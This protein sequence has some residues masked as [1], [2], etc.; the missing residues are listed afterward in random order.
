MRT[1]KQTNRSKTLACSYL[2]AK[3]GS[4]I[5]RAFVCACETVDLITL[6]CVSLFL[7]SFSWLNSVKGHMRSRQT[8]TRRPGPSLWRRSGPSSSSS[9]LLLQLLLLL[10]PTCTHGHTHPSSQGSPILF[11]SLPLYSVAAT[12]SILCGFWF[13]VVFRLIVSLSRG[14]NK[15]KCNLCTRASYTRKEGKEGEEGR[16]GKWGVGERGRGRRHHQHPVFLSLPHPSFR[17]YPPFPAPT[18]PVSL[19]LSLRDC[20]RFVVVFWSLFDC[21]SALLLLLLVTSSFNSLVFFS[22]CDFI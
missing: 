16:E 22:L 14:G 1:R 18:S 5:E 11:L 17:S 9:S 21:L 4:I 12:L 7:S 13:S 8:A 20:R 6:L 3:E 19:S 15:L 10:L 2:N